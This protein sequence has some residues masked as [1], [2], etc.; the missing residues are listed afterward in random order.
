MSDRRCGAP[1]TASTNSTPFPI[2]PHSLYTT[3][4]I[5]TPTTWAS[6]PLSSTHPFL[7]NHGRKRHNPAHPPSRRGFEATVLVVLP[8]RPL[9]FRSSFCRGPNLQALFPLL[10]AL[11]RLLLSV[12][13][14]TLD[15]NIERTLSWEYV[16]F[17]NQL[18]RSYELINNYSAKV[19]AY[20]YRF[21]SVRS[22]LIWTGKTQLIDCTNSLTK[23]AII[24]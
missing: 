12:L 18:S 4:Y 14:R 21:I 9:Q 17:I 16:C 11:P 5:S 1:L 19:N 22:I 10:M 24:I 20:P 3:T 7:N 13:N 2:H 8:T 15:L 6:H 23:F